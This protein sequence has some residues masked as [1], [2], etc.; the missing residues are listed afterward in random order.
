[1]VGK[2]AADLVVDGAKSSH[3]LELSS[4]VHGPEGVV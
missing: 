3:V 4:D 1:M 2:S